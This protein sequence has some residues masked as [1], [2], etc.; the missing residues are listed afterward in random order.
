MYDA[1]AG[2]VGAGKNI[3]FSAYLQVV[4]VTGHECQAVKLGHA[5]GQRPR[6]GFVFGKGAVD[7]LQQHIADC[8]P[9]K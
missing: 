7:W 1:Y 5:Q 6:A 9:D 8:K 3:S 4:T 2:C